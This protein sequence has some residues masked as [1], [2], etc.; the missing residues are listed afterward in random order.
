M[1]P[2]E[3]LPELASR[4]SEAGLQIDPERLTSLMEHPMNAVVSLG[5]CTAS[6]V[7][8]KGLVITNHHC[9]YGSIQYNSSPENNLLEKGFLAKNLEDELP[10]SPGSRVYVTVEFRDVTSQV[11]GD[12]PKDLS[13]KK[14]F[15]QIEK[16]RKEIVAKCEE[17]E[18]YRCRVASYYGGLKY[19]LVRQLELRDVRLVYAPAAGI[20][21][22]GGDIDNWMWPRHTGDYSF[23]RAYVGRDGTPADHSK[24]NVPFEPRHF[25]RVSTDGLKE[26]D[27]A[28]VVG[29]PGSTSRYRLSTEV[30]DV[31]K[32]GYPR[33]I[34]AYS[35]WL[36]VIDK[37]SAERPEAAMKYAGLKS[38][39]NN[40]LKNNQGMLE[41]FAK[42]NMLD[43]KRA[44]ETELANWVG[45]DQKRKA[46]YEEAL[47][48]LSLRLEED[49]GNQQRDS[50]YSMLRRAQLFA[51]ARRLYRLANEKEKSDMERESGYQERD[52]KRI[53][54]SMQAM[55]RRFDAKVDSAVWKHFILAYH[56]LPSGSRVS[57]FDEWF[58]LTPGVDPGSSLDTKLKGMYENTSLDKVESRLKLLEASVQELQA[59]SD[60][61]L[62]L[63]AA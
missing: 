37:A 54:Q 20:G 3:Q 5:G 13:G 57:D 25:L 6:F 11:L 1:W 18:G 21:V 31:F 50:R 22:F 61:F 12:M 39:L 34:K 24:D 47:H 23:Y 56:E 49:R 32:K 14:R 33:R 42:S 27:Y 59:S 10:A 60:P 62:Q 53:R 2:P 36:A 45:S 19:S 4:L 44:L 40:G 38:G 48:E 29:Y 15:D 63:P 51:A 28:M 7:S 9:A 43:K 16:R 26:G 17:K 55:D 35:D 58:K 52:F 41:G 30:E 8:P 46:T